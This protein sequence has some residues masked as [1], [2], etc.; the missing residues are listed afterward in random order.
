MNISKFQDPSLHIFRNGMIGFVCSA[1]LFLPVTQLT[2]S[3]WQSIYPVWSN[4][5]DLMGIF[6]CWPMTAVGGFLFG[7]VGGYLGSKIR[8]N[9]I[10][11][12]I[13]SA[14]SGILVGILIPGYMTFS[15]V[16]SWAPK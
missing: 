1:V 11:E 5:D 14:V 15:V 13:G 8:Q 12:I 4:V 7:I 16:Q 6:I 3:Y 2:L 9:S 10:V